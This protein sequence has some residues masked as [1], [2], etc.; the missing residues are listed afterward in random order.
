MLCPGRPH[1]HLGT[2]PHPP[3]SARFR[4]HEEKKKKYGH[5][6]L[7]KTKIIFCPAGI[8]TTQSTHRDTVETKTNS[9]HVVQL[10]LAKSLCYAS[11][12]SVFHCPGKKKKKSLRC[13]AP[14]AA[15]RLQYS[16][17]HLAPCS[18]EAGRQ[19]ARHHQRIREKTQ[20]RTH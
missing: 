8:N 13:A 18:R 11:F 12:K 7:E 5:R 3:I 2:V 16:P 4:P 19:V 14:I 9:V 20:L 10:F 1:T 6:L 17:L 15:K